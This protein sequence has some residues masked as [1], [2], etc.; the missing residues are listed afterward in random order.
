M[1]KEALVE[2]AAQVLHFF[3]KAVPLMIAAL[4]G[5]FTRLSIDKLLGKSVPLGKAIAST[6]IALVAGVSVGLLLMDDNPTG[7]IVWA[8]AS[9]VFGEKIILWLF[10]NWDE[11]MR[12]LINL[13]GKKYGNGNGQN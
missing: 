5:F 1:A 10:M 3:A 6:F 2:A 11:V 4:V 12:F 8:V 7:A 9:G 13:V